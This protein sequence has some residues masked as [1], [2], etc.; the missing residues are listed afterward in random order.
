[1]HRVLS[2]LFL[3]GVGL[4][5]MTVGSSGW[6]RSRSLGRFTTGVAGVALLV[7]TWVLGKFIS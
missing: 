2:L 6:I 4:F 5:M 3:L 7:A 1:L